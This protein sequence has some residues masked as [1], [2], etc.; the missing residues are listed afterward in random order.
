MRYCNL[1]SLF[2]RLVAILA[3]F[4]IVSR[5]RPYSR[6]E[7][8]F[9]P[10]NSRCL[11]LFALLACLAPLPLAA[12]EEPGAAAQVPTT[13]PFTETGIAG[14]WD[15]RARVEEVEIASGRSLR[16]LTSDDFP[17]LHFG[18]PDAVPTGFS[19]ELARLAC[20]RLQVPCTIQ[21]RSF[22]TLLEALEQGE[23][24]VV[25]AAFAGDERLHGRFA[26][27]LPYF[28]FPAR[29]AARAEDAP[30]AVSA[31]DLVNRRVGV[32]ADSA[33]AA[34]LAR[35][36]PDAVPVPA[37]NAAIARSDLQRGA[38]DLVFGDGLSL[39]LWIGGRASQDCCVFVGEPYFDEL[40]FGEGIGFVMRSDDVGLARA[41]DHA[42]HR[43]WED[44]G[45]AR[46]WLA[47][48]PIS[49]FEPAGAFLR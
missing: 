14:F 30:M 38:S 22:G 9:I 24:D 41:F 21:A 8:G 33:H 17:P 48:F 27:T 3:Q 32:V 47:F 49:P 19:V 5:Y 25:A 10:A 43:I 37:P 39:A 45:Y 1:E 28:R 6:T 2:H 29:F 35:Y 31:A 40:Y 20:E 15:P 18:G 42:L 7:P 44:G 13:P 11:A 34:W 23:G 4:N 16:I 46:T 36:F 12:Q 26:V